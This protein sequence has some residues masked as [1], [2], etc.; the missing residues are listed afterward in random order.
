MQCNEIQYDALHRNAMQR[1]GIQC[2]AMLCNTMQMQCDANAI[3]WNAPQ[4]YF[5]LFLVDVVVVR[6][7]ESGSFV[8]VFG[9]QIAPLTTSLR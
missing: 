6:S 7:S 8:V 5:T 9:E 3:R 2:D 4:S 1:N